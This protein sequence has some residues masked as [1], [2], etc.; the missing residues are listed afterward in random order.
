MSS[1][2]DTNS[3]LQNICVP[4]SYPV[5]FTRDFANP[6]NPVLRNTMTVSGESGGLACVF[7]D[8]GV[9]ASHQRIK[10]QVSEYMKTVSDSVRLVADPYILPGGEEIKNGWTSVMRILDSLLEHRL[11]RHSFVIAIGGGAFLDAVGFA[12]GMVHRGLRLIRVPTTTLAQGD[13]GIGVKNGINMGSVKNVLGMFSPPYAVINDYT[14]LVTLERDMMLDG[15]AEACKV[16][17]IKDRNL[18]SYIQKHAHDIYDMKWN[19]IEEVVHWSAEIHRNH[20]SMSSDPFEFGVSRPLDF[21]HWSAH[22]L[23]SMSGYTVR[24]G[25]AVSIGIVLDSCYALHTEN[26]TLDEYNRIVQTMKHVGLPVYS[27]Y[28]TEYTD[29]NTLRVLEG[30]ELFREHIGGNLA[31][32]IPTGIGQCTE[33]HHMDSALIQT[34]IEYMHSHEDMI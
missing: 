24:H 33:I 22:M 1:L 5:Y 31:I 29:N 27:S 11:C 17:I 26:I 16:A 7:I 8:E 34:C 21:G 25:Q 3:S 10:K 2:F 20:I 19:Y 18:F 9:Y 23:E 14:L 12:C 32:T 15:I 30:I 28:L 4:F 6:E 13:S